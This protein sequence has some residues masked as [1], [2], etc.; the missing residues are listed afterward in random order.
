M[1]TAITAPLPLFADLDG[2][3]LD[4][5]YVYVGTS[6]ANPETSPITV[7]WDSALTQPTAQPLRTAGGQIVRNGQPSA[8]YASV[9]DYSLTV[10]DKRRQLIAYQPSAV[11]SNNG[12]AVVALIATLASTATGK[13]ASTIGVEDAAGIA[14]TG[15][16]KNVEAYLHEIALQYAIPLRRYLPAG[17]VAGRTDATS[18]WL[19]AATAAISS[20]NGVVACEGID[21]LL[22]NLAITNFEAGVKFIGPA[23]NSQGRRANIIQKDILNPAIKI[24]GENVN[25]DGFSCT[26]FA[27]CALDAS[28][29]AITVLSAS[30]TTMVLSADPWPGMSP[31]IWSGFG[32]DPRTGTSLAPVA[33]DTTVYPAA[34]RLNAYGAWLA[35]GVTKNGDGTVTLTG[36][37]G[38][39]GTL[40]T[41]LS[42][43]VGQPVSAFISLAHS[44]SDASFTNARAGIFD[45][46]VRENQV[47]RNIWANQAGML[48]SY[49]ALGSGGGVDVGIGNAGFMDTIICDQVG[50][51][52]KSAGDINALQASNVQLFGARHGLVAAGNMTDCQIDGLKTIACMEFMNIA[53]NVTGVNIDGNFEALT[54]SNYSYTNGFIKVGGLLSDS[55]FSGSIFGRSSSSGGAVF[56]LATVDG[57]TLS[58]CTIISHAEGGTN[59]FM[60]VSGS[61][62]KRVKMSGN[63]WEGKYSSGALKIVFTDTSADITGTV[64]EDEVADAT[65]HTQLGWQTPTFTNSWAQAAGAVP[66][67]FRKDY[68][69]KMVTMRGQMTG[70]AT[71][72]SAFTLPSWA[73]PVADYERFIVPISGNNTCLIEARTTGTVTPTF[74]ASNSW[75]SLSGIR[76]LGV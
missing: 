60:S 40:N 3:P 2:S 11:A 10:R 13:G 72:N 14:Q 1:T 73:R 51:W 22:S 4:S 30:G 16:T 69:S 61:T 76:F 68:A 52:I 50:W 28:G 12:L 43:T 15:T 32:T 8:V 71:G 49:D 6:G 62:F 44:L 17:Y 37:R 59:G 5:G 48:F 38:A 46:D 74:S 70:G 42:S 63:A 75:V 7:Y 45:V 35:S 27:G 41:S 20:G 26:V 56:Q 19:A 9:S 39:A 57:L 53:G 47:F 66:V 24:S 33:T 25:F 18:A 67:Q 36:V 64:L 55:N 29:N 31:V 65:N 34:I 21:Y 54:G 23:I 58:A